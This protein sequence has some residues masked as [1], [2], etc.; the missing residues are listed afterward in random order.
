[1]LYIKSI[2][3]ILTDKTLQLYTLHVNCISVC[4]CAP[5]RETNLE[6]HLARVFSTTTKA[7]EQEEMRRKT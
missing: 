3:I 7:K 5:N 4:F 1:M 6:M 2:N